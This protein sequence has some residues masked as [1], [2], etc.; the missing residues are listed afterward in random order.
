[1][2]KKKPPIFNPNADTTKSTKISAEEEKFLKGN[3]TVVPKVEKKKG[4]KNK[5]HTFSMSDDFYET[6]GRFVAKHPHEGSLSAMLVRAATKY[7]K[8]EDP[9][10]EIIN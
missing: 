7:M 6:I 4:K 2:A 8:N 1:M 10:F 9:D 3:T 5:P